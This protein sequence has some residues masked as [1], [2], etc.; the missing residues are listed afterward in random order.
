MFKLRPKIDRHAEDKN[1]RN[2]NAF[3]GPAQNSIH[4]PPLTDPLRSSGAHARTPFVRTSIEP[5]K[6]PVSRFAQQATL[7]HMNHPVPIQLKLGRVPGYV[8]A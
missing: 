8:Q 4:T 6:K 5:Q 3:D 1:G 7:G 2:D